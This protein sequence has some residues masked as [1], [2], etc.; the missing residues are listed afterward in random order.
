[1]PIGA[2]AND[3]D[4]K[5]ITPAA[6]A[7]LDFST[8]TLLDLREPDEV[9]VHGIDGAINIPFNQ[10]GKRLSQVPQDKPVIVFCRVG[11]WSEEVTE[12]LA[13]R[14]YDAINLDGGFQA[15]REYLR[16]QEQSGKDSNASEA[17][18]VGD[19]A[20]ANADSAHTAAVNIPVAAQQLS[21]HSAGASNGTTDTANATDNATDSTGS[22]AD[23][24]TG[25]HV[26]VDAKG[27]KCPGPIVKIADTLR[28]LPIGTRLTAEATEDAFLS[29]IAV[30]C[31]R[32]GNRLVE[33]NRDDT[34]VIHVIIDKTAPA[35]KPGEPAIAC[36][37]AGA[38]AAS[39][40]V[41]SSANVAVTAAN[42]DGGDIRHDKT[43]V[44]FS[45]DLDKTIAVFIMANGAAAMGRKVTVFFTF[46]GLNILRKPKHVRVRKSLIE[47]MFGMMMPRGTKKLGLSRMNMGGIGAK[48]IRWI[49]KSK[50]V[51]S[52]E[53]LMQQAVDH[54]VRL[55]A[56]QMSMDIMG[57]HKE[58]LIDGVELGGVST[59]LGSGETS[60]MSLF[61]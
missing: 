34:G 19:T 12:I 31:E 49:M 41:A 22:A 38:A 44:V 55:V 53:S 36:S 17:T 35:A 18:N 45:G 20:S 40:N 8:V 42:P 51:E 54:G 27:L 48:M 39:A 23:S 13:D 30:W 33:L 14:G 7:A 28:P 61:V 60:D 37:A 29:D 21:V 58:E 10:I 6:F 5:R 52:L 2:A 1:M 11:D 9:L 43:F 46:W 24:K 59:F 4:I 57:I 26:F 50:N 47:H 15:Y 32:T 16:E 56:C 25:K 3:D